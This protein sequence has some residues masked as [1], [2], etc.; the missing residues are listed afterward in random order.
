MKRTVRFL[1]LCLGL[2]PALGAQ[3][4]PPHIGYVYPAGCRQGSTVEVLVGGQYLANAQGAYA[5]GGG[6]DVSI[7]DYS[8]P[9]APREVAQ[10][11]E[12]LEELQKKPRDAAVL[13][14]M[15]EIRGKIAGSLRRN[16]NPALA[17]TVTLRIAAAPEAE[18]GVRELRLATPIG[19]SNPVL[20]HIGRLP[21]FSE[22]PAEAGAA[23]VADAEAPLEITIPAVVNGRIVPHAA[24]RPQ[25]PARA[26]RG[27]ASGDVDRY[28][29]AARR[30]QS[31]VIAVSARELIPYLADAVPGWFQADLTLYDEAGREV[32]YDDDYRF[33]PDP[34][35]HYEVPADG[36]YTIEIKDALYRGREDFVYRVSIGELPFVTGIFPLGG[37]AGERT[38]LD[39]RGWNL[40]G[41]RAVMDA[42]G[43]GPGIYPFAV[44]VGEQVSNAAP[45]MVDTLPEV[46]ER[47]ANDTPDKAH[48]VQP[49]VVVHG[50]LGRPGDTDVFRFEGRAGQII[51]AEV[52]ARRL[53]SPVD[54]VLRLTDAAG[55][56]LAANDDHEDKAFGWIT[57]HADSFVMAALPADGSYYVHLGEAQ[58]KGGTEYA[59]RLRIGPPRPDFELRVVPSSI[60]AAPGMTVPVAVHALR[61]DG[62]SGE[63]ALALR[64]TSGRVLLSGGLVPPG[65]DK[66]RVTLTVPQAPP[67]E[68]LSLALEGRATIEGRESVRAA[69]PAD[70]MQQAFA[71]R[72][73]VP[74]Q[75]LKVALS[76]RPAFRVP[77]RIEGG[78][79][80]KIGLGTGARIRVQYR[81]P[82]NLAR[83]TLRFELSEP[84][85]G[86]TLREV[87]PFAGG[88]ELVLD[89]DGAKAK[90]GTR[91]NLIVEVFTERSIPPQ[92][93]GA[94]PVTRRIPLGTLP[95]IPFEFR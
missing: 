39:V 8:R 25:A 83:E 32:A 76:R 37:R 21:E 84:P 34:V 26:G 2:A 95:A 64:G 19:L 12:R 72:H 92:K 1:T 67:G 20:F 10:L 56:E 50:H 82:A 16:A 86:L 51:V 87:V 24:P 90:A 45:F 52:Y 33:H 29:F 43:K 35:L 68:V 5:S 78:R 66:I 80:V 4:N 6:V 7:A 61:K 3:Q 62:F 42:A 59:Y 77:V 41:A 60:N 11:R 36:R 57:H 75:E 69:I 53:D 74:S 89:C 91:G 31:L 14:E 13:K 18:P 63:I 30:G 22:A 94:R 88:V 73:L 70:E 85:E 65:E 23:P 54:S 40:P 49:P 79:P 48:K 27:S 9:L 17:E 46:I 28:R 47:E 81:L 55:R 44:R 93:E 15:M 38:A 58:R 71:Y